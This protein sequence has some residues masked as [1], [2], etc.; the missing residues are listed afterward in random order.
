MKLLR[1]VFGAKPAAKAMHAQ[2]RKKAEILKG[3]AEILKMGG[4]LY[5]AAFTEGKAHGYMEC[6]IA[7]IGEEL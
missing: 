7:C 3:E 2:L 5:K 6:A 4:N 1:K